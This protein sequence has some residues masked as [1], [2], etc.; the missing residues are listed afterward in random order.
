MSRGLLKKKVLLHKI[1]HHEL[2]EW[3]NHELNG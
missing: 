1:G 2:V 3:V